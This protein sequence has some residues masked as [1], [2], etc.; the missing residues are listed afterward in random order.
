MPF[1]DLGVPVDPALLIWA[2]LMCDP[3]SD[4]VVRCRRSDFDNPDVGLEFVL[5]FPLAELS[6]SDVPLFVA[7][8]VMDLGLWF[9]TVLNWRDRIP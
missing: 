4:A 5:V 1:F 6:D 7:L 3:S 2:D 8:V 9:V